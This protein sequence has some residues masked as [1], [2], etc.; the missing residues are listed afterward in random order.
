MVTN[1][2]S[3]QLKSDSKQKVP[4]FVFLKIYFKKKRK[5]M[6]LTENS[7]LSFRVEAFTCMPICEVVTV[8]EFTTMDVQ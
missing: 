1:G 2:Q 6:A 7:F 4:A 8:R 3:I 5:Y